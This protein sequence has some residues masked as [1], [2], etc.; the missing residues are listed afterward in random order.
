MLRVIVGASLLLTASVPAW[1]DA[2]QD[3]ARKSGSEAIAACDAALAR[4]PN[5]AQ[6]YLN[7]G[8][9]YSGIREYQRAISDFTKAIDLQQRPNAYYGRGLAY[10]EMGEY[11]KALADADQ[12]VT[13]SATAQ[14]SVTRVDGAQISSAYDRAL[15]FYLRCLIY[16]RRN[17]PNKAV[18]DC[19]SAINLHATRHSFFGI[20]AQNHEKLGNDQAAIADFRQALRLN[21]SYEAAREGLSRLGAKP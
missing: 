15:N 10:Y 19:T 20:R 8:A 21:P 16:N 4:N 7:R 13:R 5:D 2:R 11:D 1:G 18:A 17:E 6:S 3:C 9:E 12:A 14:G